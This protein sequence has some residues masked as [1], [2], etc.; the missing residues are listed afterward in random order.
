MKYSLIIPTKNRQKYA[1]HAIRAALNVDYRDYEIIVQ[2]CSDDRSLFDWLRK[3]GALDRVLY[4]GAPSSFSMTENWNQGIDAAKGDYISVIGDDDAILSDAL[5]W[6]DFYLSKHPAEVITTAS[7]S[8]NWPDYPFPPISNA[9]TFKTGINATL[10]P[11]CRVLLRNGLSHKVRVGTGPSVYRKIVSSELIDRVKAARGVYIKDFIPDFDSGYMNM[12]FGR[13]ILDVERP[14]FVSGAGF[15][16]N[17]GSMMFPKAQRRQYEQFADEAG[18]DLQAMTDLGGDQLVSNSAT[19]VAAQL[20]MLPE[21]RSLSGDH[22]L[23][24][25]REGAWR[26]MLQKVTERH[27]TSLIDGELKKLDR[28][29]KKWGIQSRVPKDFKL[30][31]VAGIVHQQG[32]RFADQGAR[33]KL[34][35]CIDCQTVGV[36]EVKGAADLVQSILPTIHSTRDEAAIAAFERGGRESAAELYD[37]ALALRGDG[38]T[39][40]AINELNNLMRRFPEFGLAYDVL[41]SLL[42]EQNRADEADVVKSN[43]RTLIGARKKTGK[44]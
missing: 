3:T 10:I 31:P 9:L 43:K 6:S 19:I 22:T 20:R 39:D 34:S 17:S 40:G 8:Y 26:Y 37:R 23:D 5:L 27:D 42:L 38:Q 32:L 24:V 15:K 30:L 35:V 2:D 18:I 16:S 1:K 11:D 29:A 13:S 33:D 36:S 28:L 12:I 4:T 21:L 7:A 44:R 41:I 14:L 25:D